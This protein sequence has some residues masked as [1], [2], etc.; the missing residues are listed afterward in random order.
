MDVNAKSLNPEMRWQRERFQAQTG[1]PKA[2]WVIAKEVFNLFLAFN[3][4]Q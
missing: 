4:M 1:N 2:T 3:L